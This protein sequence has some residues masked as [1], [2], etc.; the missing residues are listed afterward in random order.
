MLCRSLKIL[1]ELDAAK[2]IERLEKERISRKINVPSLIISKVI[3]LA[4][5][6]GLSNLNL[7]SSF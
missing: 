5:V 4:L 6:L 3:D 2:E 7:D 1:D